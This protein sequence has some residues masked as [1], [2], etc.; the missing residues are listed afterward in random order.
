METFSALLAI[1]VVNSPVPD[2]FP[3][4]RPVTW[5]FDFCFDLRPN[6]LL[7]KQSLGWRFEMPSCP[8]WYHRNDRSIFCHMPP[9]TALSSYLPLYNWFSNV[10]RDHFYHIPNSLKYLFCPHP[11]FV[12]LW[13]LHNV[14]HDMRATVKCR[15]NAVLGVQEI[16]RLIAVTVL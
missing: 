9:Q 14:V 6:K 2:E 13:S 12:K 10:A 11:D 15:Y 3:A 1:C 8:L 7:S 5:T 16:D 4:Q